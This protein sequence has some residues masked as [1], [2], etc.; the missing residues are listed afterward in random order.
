MLVINFSAISVLTVIYWNQN[1]Q[2]PC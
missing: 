1:F 2:K